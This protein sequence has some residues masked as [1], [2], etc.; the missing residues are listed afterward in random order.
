MTK[1]NDQ[2]S[3][4]LRFISSNFE[5]DFHKIA[6]V[7]IKT[8]SKQAKLEELKSLATKDAIPKEL[9]EWISYQEKSK[10][11]SIAEA[12][13]RILI[14]ISPKNSYEPNRINNWLK[15]G[16][17][18]NHLSNSLP[19]TMSYI[20]S[21]IVKANKMKLKISKLS[22]RISKFDSTDLSKR[23]KKSISSAEVAEAE[24]EVTEEKLQLLNSIIIRKLKE[25]EAILGSGG[26]L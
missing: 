25:I 17:L 9:L 4:L 3:G 11:D 21:D 23:T 15:K 10:Q 14:Y 22:D 18:P 7:E 20:F 2:A 8:K 1:T 16:K 19:S 12:L 13:S 26:S 5:N 6:D 24:A